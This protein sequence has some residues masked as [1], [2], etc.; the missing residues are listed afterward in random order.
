MQTDHCD[1]ITDDDDVMSDDDSKIE[2]YVEAD[3]L[4]IALKLLVEIIFKFV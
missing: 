1:E 3:D 4:D 2:D